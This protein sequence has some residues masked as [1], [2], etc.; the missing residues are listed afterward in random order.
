MI[1]DVTTPVISSILSQPGSG[2][3]YT[4]TNYAFLANDGTG[5]TDIFGHL[6]SGST[7]V[8]AV[9][10][11]ITAT[12]TNAPFDAIPEIG[13][14]SAIAATS[15]GNTPAA[16]TPTTVATLLGV[17]PTSFNLLGEYLTLSNVTFGSLP[18]SGIFPIHAN[19]TLSLNDSSNN[20]VTA[21]YF[22]SSYSSEDALAGTTIPTGPVNVGGIVD[23]FGTGQNAAPEFIPLSVVA[24][25][26]P[27]SLS[28]LALGGVTLLNRRRRAAR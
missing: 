26:E 24:V 14:L 17:T 10:E 15:S 2:D 12:G 4:Y 8:P 21:F 13:S 3:G 20:S 25:P 23:I 28:V 22:A 6:P 7:F 18:S 5:S 9:G 16:P 11:A 27:A 19:L 1:G